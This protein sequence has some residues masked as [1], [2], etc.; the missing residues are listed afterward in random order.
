MFKCSL[1][2]DVTTATREGHPHYTHSNQSCISP[3]M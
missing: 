3:Y 1:G 2:P